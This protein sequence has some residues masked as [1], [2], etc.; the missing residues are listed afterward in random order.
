MVYQQVHRISI[1]KDK[2]DLHNANQINDEGLFEFLASEFLSELYLLASV[3]P[4]RGLFL[5]KKLKTCY[6][7]ILMEWR[8]NEYSLHNIT[9]GQIRV[10][11]KTQKPIIQITLRH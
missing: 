11:S 1:T 5:S 9:K 7:L 2:T 8:F 10:R 4:K 3:L 6:L